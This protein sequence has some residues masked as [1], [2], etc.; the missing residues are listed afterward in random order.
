MTEQEL[1]EIEKEGEFKGVDMFGIQMSVIQKASFDKLIAE[2]RRLNVEINAIKGLKGYE[3]Y[4]ILQRNNWELVKELEQ[5]NERYKQ[6]L[7]YI[8]NEHGTSVYA[9]TLE[10][11]RASA[12]MILE[13]E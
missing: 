10:E 4:L 6:A 11:A 7:E 8:S 1:Q 2:V 5:Q 12:I 9:D 3:D 13:E